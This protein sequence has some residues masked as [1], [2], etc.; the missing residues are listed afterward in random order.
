MFATTF[1]FLAD[2]N[3]RN[4]SVAEAGQADLNFQKKCGNLPEGNMLSNIFS[5]K[6]YQDDDSA[7]KYILVKLEMRGTLSLN[8][9]RNYY[10]CSFLCS[11]FLVFSS[12]RFAFCFILNVSIRFR[13][14]SVI[15]CEKLTLL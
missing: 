15:D 9:G 1:F 14:D 8:E 4:G 10:P 2:N 12:L 13:Y 6:E 11:Q 7:G 5:D 3:N